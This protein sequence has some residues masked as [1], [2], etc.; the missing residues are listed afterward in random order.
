M[1][2]WIVYNAA[3]VEVRVRRPDG[4]WLKGRVVQSVF[5]GS[6]ADH[7]PGAFIGLGNAVEAE[8]KA[9]RKMVALEKA[10][11]FAEKVDA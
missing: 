8:V 1:T 4:H 3:E 6:F 11:Q 5:G 9:L 10:R 7:C 2:D